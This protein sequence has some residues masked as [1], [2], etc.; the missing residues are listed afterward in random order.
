M[1]FLKKIYELAAILS[2]LALFTGCTDNSVKKS[3][4]AANSAETTVTASEDASEQADES[5]E[6]MGIASESPTLP[7]DIEAAEGT[8]IYDNANVLSDEQFKACNDYIETLY[9]NY[10]LNAAVVTSN[11]L[12]DSS[13][14]EYAEKMYTELYS[15]LGSGLL[16][17]INNDTNEDYLYR[18]GSCSAYI[19]DDAVK[20]TFYWATR[21]MVADDWQSAVL[22]LMQLGEG[23]PSHVFDNASVFSSDEIT[24]IETTL[25]SYSNDVAVLATT[26][27]TETSDEDVLN[28]YYERHCKDGKGYML[29]LNTAANRLIV[30]SDNTLPSDMEDTLKAA[31]ETAEK[32]DYKGA[33]LAAAEKLKG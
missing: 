10:L 26:N 2:A 23:C 17:L 3:E 33:V 21:D 31:N 28:A 22:R 25:G 19:T 1:I 9:E 8:Y 7:A 6:D 14:E 20:Q 5:A 12:G 4:K 29:M 27:T 32:G 11:D 30:K 16:L 15:G 13:A 24:E 18:T